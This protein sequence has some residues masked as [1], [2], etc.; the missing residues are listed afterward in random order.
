M[1]QDTLSP[2]QPPPEKIVDALR[3]FEQAVGGR[4]LLA[5]A[6]VHSPQDEADVIARLLADPDNERKSLASLCAAASISFGKF[7]KIFASARGA[8][9]YLKAMD[10][11]WH[12]APE[13]A[14]DAMR[15]ARTV[16]RTCRWCRGK[17]YHRKKIQVEN[18]EEG[19]FYEG[20]IRQGFK[21]ILCQACKGVGKHEV[22]PEPERV[23]IALRLAGLLKE[24]PRT[25]VDLSKHQTNQVVVADSMRSFIAATNRLLYGALPPSPPPE[26]DVIDVPSTPVVEES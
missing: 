8:A 10:R 9:A 7:L 11:V 16:S 13:V 24:E 3:A 14:A 12:E 2:L 4:Y 17:G 20:E 23:K 21:E 15:A 18:K 6:L 25:T 5:E 22:I 1:P 26:V 19:S